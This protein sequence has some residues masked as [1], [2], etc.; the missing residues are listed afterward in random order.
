MTKYALLAAVVWAARPTPA[1]AD[2]DPAFTI[3]SRP[4]WLLLGGLTTGGTVALGDRGALVGGELSLA[5]LRDATFFGCYADGYYDWGASGTYVTG[6]IEAGHKLVGVDAGAALRM[7]GGDRDV[8]IAGRLTVG[9]G[10]AGVYVRY[11]NFP[12]AKAGDQVLQVG[13]VLKLP[14]WTSGQ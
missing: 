10:V 13:L 2:D 4:A 9:L 11:L 14:L 3:G 12:D 7:A 8:G 1:L 6:G 5:R